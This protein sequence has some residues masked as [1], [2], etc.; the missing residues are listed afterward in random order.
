MGAPYSA[1]VQPASAY[2]QLQGAA[3]LRMEAGNRAGA[4]RAMRLAG[5]VRQ[6]SAAGQLPPALAGRV[7]QETSSDAAAVARRWPWTA[8]SSGVQLDRTTAKGPRGAVQRYRFGERGPGGKHPRSL[9]AYADAIPGPS[10]R[11]TLRRPPSWTGP[12]GR[13]VRELARLQQRTMGKAGP[14]VTAFQR[15]SRALWDVLDAA[16][17]FRTADARREPGK[18]PVP[19][20][21][22]CSWGLTGADRAGLMPSD[23]T[24]RHRDACGEWWGRFRLAAHT[25]AAA[26]DELEAG[27]GGALRALVD[28]GDTQR[29]QDKRPGETAGPLRTAADFWLGPNGSRN[30][31][32][33][34]SGGLILLLIAA[35]AASGKRKGRR[36]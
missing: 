5:E 4:A 34:G 20:L 33:A 25:A 28:E 15:A 19:G 22:P 24:K 14:L 1:R 18:P 2:A 35:A 31:N 21:V 6:Q 9:I 17:P 29:K 32:R 7:R 3:I 8:G 12:A 13:A 26:A 16:P 11:W 36:S 30:R 27:Q 10:G 23:A